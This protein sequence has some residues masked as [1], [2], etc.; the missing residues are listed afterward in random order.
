MERAKGALREII[1]AY[2]SH[3]AAKLI[4]EEAF[5][6]SNKRCKAPVAGKEIVPKRGQ[7]SWLHRM[8][9]R[10]ADPAVPG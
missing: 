6:L 4:W 7:S 5:A 10:A 9:K 3:R 8:E 2:E 1:A